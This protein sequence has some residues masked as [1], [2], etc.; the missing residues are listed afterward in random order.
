MKFDWDES[1]AKKNFQK[2]GISFPL[3]VTVFD[4]PFALI[5]PDDRHSSRMEKREW[6][7][8]KADRGILV[9]VFTKRLYGRIYRIISARKANKKERE[10][11]ENYKRIPI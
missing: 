4:D 5:A 3:A 7:I 2:H 1:K 10:T 11:Y 6:I 9:V 8:G